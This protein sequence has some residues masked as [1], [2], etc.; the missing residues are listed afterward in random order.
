MKLAQNRRSPPAATEI[1]RVVFNIGGGKVRHAKLNGRD[2]LVVPTVMMTEGVHEGSAG[3][4]FY[5][6]VEL[7]K[8][9]FQWNHMP[10][11]VYHSEDENGKPKSARDPDVLNAQ[12]IGL[13]LNTKT[14][15]KKQHTEAWLD[16]KL[17][18]KTDKRI[19]AALENNQKVEVSTGVGVR[20]VRQKGKWGD[21]TYK[22]KAAN[23]TPDHLAV[24]PDQKGACSIEDGAGMLQFN[25]AFKKLG[26]PE[27]K[28][29]R[30][31]V[32]NALKRV[33]AA[34]VNNELSF[35]DT[36]SAVSSALAAAYGEKGKYWRGYIVDLYPTYVVFCTDYGV[37]GVYYKVSYTVS[38]SGTVSLGDDKKEVVRT[39]EYKPVNNA[40][41]I[42]VTNEGKGMKLAVKKKMIRLV[43]KNAGIT[44]KAAKALEVN[45]LRAV[46]NA[47]K[48]K[49]AP[50]PA[51]KQVVNRK[52]IIKAGQ[53]LTR[54]DVLNMLSKQERDV[55]NRGIKAAEKERAKNIEVIKNAKNCPFKEDALKDPE[56]FGDELLAGMAAMVTANEDQ[57]DD[58]S[59]LKADFSGADGARGDVNNAADDDDFMEIE[60]PLTQY[61]K[62]EKSA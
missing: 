36:T 42:T 28:V 52:V 1:E 20:K 62:K 49:A 8:S 46:Y 26:P 45:D 10:I 16:Y 43:V 40:G 34:F 60:D 3:P 14:R 50:E 19:I 48:K 30:R 33:G 24:L 29:L 54:D 12:K 53:K 57:G 56:K 61:T 9:D 15:G 4:G 21:E 55:I 6:A 22:W 51:G 47:T 31:A 59:I 13:V 5:S 2:H 44:E 38:K 27:R 58:D 7:M 39:T 11:V 25:A 18:K 37:S 35:G 41:R 17:T 23:I 32:V